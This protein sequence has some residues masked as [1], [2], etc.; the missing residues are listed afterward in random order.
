MI[1]NIDITKVISREAIRTFFQPIISIRQKAVVGLESLSQGIAVSEA[2]ASVA[3]GVGGMIPPERLFTMAEASGLTVELDRLCREKALE[4]F[5]SI[6]Q[7]PELFL[8]LNFKTSIID[9]GV[10]GSGHLLQQVLRHHLNPENIVIEIVESEVKDLEALAEFVQSYKNHGFLIALDDFGAGYSNLDR[11]AVIKPDIIKIDRSLLHHFD[12]EYY[13][14]EMVKSLIRLSHKLGA[15]A[16][17]EG[18]E[19]AAEAILAVELGADMLQGYYFSKPVPGAAINPDDYQGLIDDTALLYKTIMM[20]WAYQL[21]VRNDQFYTLVHDFITVLSNHP[22]EHFNE[23]LAEMIGSHFSLECVYILNGT[24]IQVSNTI[25][26]FVSI[27]KQKRRIFTP[28]LKGADQSLKEYYL[29]IQGG[30][31]QYITEP[32]ISSAS[33]NACV[34]VSAVFTGVNGLK[35]ILCL[36]VQA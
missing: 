17:A 16:I 10:V 1:H 7:K 31:N 36:D 11:V 20:E 4:A 28:S 29:P 25:F 34:T 33:G 2:S 12:R 13:K 30:R 18:V 5:Q 8:A 35:Y 32:Y 19:T 3:D 9:Q 6:A 22:P 21:K 26:N 23:R 15:L 24:G 14:Q 27:P